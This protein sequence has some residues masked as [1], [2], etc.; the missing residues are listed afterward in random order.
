M[1]NRVKGD[2]RALGMIWTGY[3]ICKE[4]K[5]GFCLKRQ[6]QTG[7][8]EPLIGW[9]SGKT[10][11]LPLWERM[12][13]SWLWTQPVL[14]FP[15]WWNERQKS[16][17]ATLCVY[18]VEA[19]PRIYQLRDS[20]SWTWTLHVTEHKTSNGT[21]LYKRLQG[22]E[23]ILKQSKHASIAG[24]CRGQ[25]HDQ[26]PN[27]WTYNHVEVSGH[28]QTWGFCMDFLS[29]REVGVVFYQVFL[30][31]LLQ[32]LQEVAWVGRNRNLKQSCRGDC[33]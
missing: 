24:K 23:S 2:G 28:N 25:V 10:T 15:S 7:S 22:Q 6:M 31:S 8:S 20:V 17:I 26:K 18:S 14:I 32:K 33:E 5:T 1:V 13:G 4:V 27:Y 9:K 16:A 3:L 19:P 30:L 21:K 12:E 29:H 11:Y